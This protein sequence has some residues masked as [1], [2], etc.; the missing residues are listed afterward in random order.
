MVSIMVYWSLLITIGIPLSLVF[1]LIWI[2]KIK[3]NSE[4]QV[5]QNN[6]IIQL[7]EERKIE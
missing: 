6:K 1:L 7:L 2:Y 4:I 5:E 3:R